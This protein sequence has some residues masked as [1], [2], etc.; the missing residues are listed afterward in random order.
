MTE[1]ARKVIAPPPARHHRAEVFQAFVLVVAALFVGLA[2][3]AHSV[4]Y[5]QLDLSISRALQT[6]QGDLFRRIMYAVSW[7]G[8]FPQA[9]ILGVA[10]VS[11]L[12][13]AGLRWEAVITLFAQLCTLVGGL[14]KVAVLRPRPGTD[15]VHVAQQLATASF[16]SGHVLGATALFGFLGFLAFTLL[17]PSWARSA[18]L[19]FVAI[20]IFLMGPSRIYLGQHWFSD[21]IGG[22][23]FG[24]LWLALTIWVYRWGKPRFFRRQPIAPAAPS[25][26]GK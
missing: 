17:K 15:L 13:L 24:S 10:T 22:Y 1:H 14:I 9:M 12:F 4:P 20:V 5:F 2:V 26:A 19:A 11:A 3:V 23:L 8:F 25:P 21:V 7:I 6:E 16:P 18:M